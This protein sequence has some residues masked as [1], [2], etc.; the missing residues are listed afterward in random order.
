MSFPVGARKQAARN[1][2][3]NDQLRPADLARYGCTNLSAEC[4]RA[5]KRRHGLARSQVHRSDR[6]QRQSLCGHHEET[7]LQN[8]L[9]NNTTT[10]GEIV[11]T[12]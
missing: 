8:R 11:C 1:A 2:R 3:A 9:H 7:I 4:G 12:D 10:P 6:G 5:T